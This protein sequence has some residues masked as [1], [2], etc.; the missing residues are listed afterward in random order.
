MLKYLVYN[1]I[2]GIIGLLTVAG[3]N[4]YADPAHLFSGGR[5]EKRMADILASGAHVANISD[6]DERIMQDYY[7]SNLRERKEVIVLGSSR[8]LQLRSDLFPGMSFFNHS[9]SGAT[10]EDYLAIY[11][12][13]RERNFKPSIVV[14]GLDPWILNK[15]NGQSRWRSLKDEYY[16]FQKKINN[17]PDIQPRRMSIDIKQSRFIQLISLA[18][19]EE[20]VKELLSN[21]GDKTQGKFYATNDEK[22]DKHTIL[23]DGSRLYPLEM[24]LL[25]IDE[26]ERSAISFAKNDPV[27][28]L[29]NFAKLDKYSLTILENFVQY[30]QNNKVQVIFYLPPYHPS[31]FEI[32]SQ[33]DK[34]SI[35]LEVEEYYRNLAKHMEIPI[36]GGYNPDDSGC[37]RKDFFDGM[38]PKASCDKKAFRHLY[39]EFASRG[40]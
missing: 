36:Y 34:Y 15:Y 39:S 6:Y 19:L 35:I 31:S 14:L 30:L 16:S 20:S 3:I 11:G 25:T 37:D 4:Y 27:Y 1:A 29:A 10:I 7:I 24:R 17:D 33:S 26:V 5:Y 13:Y 38:H 2:L 32:L 28:S 8:S 18:Y 23:A 9:V 21:I 12:L 40:Q 22:N